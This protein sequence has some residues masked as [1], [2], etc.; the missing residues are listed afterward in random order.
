M[1]LIEQ[2]NLSLQDVYYRI[3][4]ARYGIRNVSRK[5]IISI[6]Q[7][8]SAPRFYITP[9]TAQLY[10][11]NNNQCRN[12]GRKQDMIADLMDNYNRLKRENPNAPKMWLYET[13][14][15]Q[16]AKSFYMSA[17]RIE[18]IIFNYTGRNGKSKK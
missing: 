8:M 13:V 6:I 15:E 3:I 4:K 18:E 10:I 1:T 11:N 5:T 9:F 14:V 7:E 2:R 12:R 17:H 16:P